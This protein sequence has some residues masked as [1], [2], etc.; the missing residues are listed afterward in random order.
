LKTYVSCLFALYNKLEGKD[1][2][3][4]F[5][6]N[7]NKIIDSLKDSNLNK[8]KTVLSSLFILTNNE[9]Y[10]EQMLIF[11][12]EVNDNYKK[13]V[14]NYKQAKNWVTFDEVTKKFNEF[15]NEVLPM[16]NNKSP[17]VIKDIIK[18]FILAFNNLIDPRR[19]LDYCMMKIRNYDS[20]KDNYYNKGKFVFNIY[21]T[22]KVYGRVIIDL[23]LVSPELDSY[24][25]KWNKINNTDYLL[26]SSINKPITPVQYCNYSNNIWGKHISTDI[27]R[28]TYI[29]NF[30][31]HPHTI[32]QQQRLAA[33][34]GH[35][36]S[37][38]VN[39]Y[40]KSDA[41]E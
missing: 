26:I 20:E 31:K 39:D 22:F 10:K 15:K 36:V 27:Y 29:T 8:K 33:D 12:K 25:K 24:I 5:K 17:I 21:K 11:C 7:V 34:M 4:F 32:E 6:N 9:K 30:L 38:A 28:A 35:S 3:D 16:L 23:K 40:Y 19:S 14:L 1:G 13:Q 41:K 37:I 2:L 18:F